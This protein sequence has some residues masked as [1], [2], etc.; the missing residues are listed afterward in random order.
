MA[1]KTNED[2]CTRIE[3]K[4]QATCKSCRSCRQK[5]VKCNGAKPVCQ[6]CEQSAIDCIYPRDFRKDTRPSKDRLQSL[7]STLSR[8]LDHMKASGID[9]PRELDL[10]DS[11]SMEDSAPDQ[12]EVSQLPTP[13]FSSGS[14]AEAVTLGARHVD[15]T[16]TASLRGNEPEPANISVGEQRDQQPGEAFDFTFQVQGQ[17]SDPPVQY[18]DRCQANDMSTIPEGSGTDTAALSHC[19][20]RVAGVFHELGC[21]SSVHGLAGV[22]NPNLRALHKKNISNL[23]WKGETALTESKA[24]LISNAVLQKQRETRLF[25]QPHDRMD[26]DGCPPDLAKHLLELHF[27]RRHHVYVL[28]YRPAFM[29]SLANGG[30]PWANKLLLNAIYYSSAMY[31]E[32]PMMSGT[33]DDGT[34]MADRFYTRFKTLLA[35]EFDSAS[36]STAAALLLVSGTLISQGKPSPGWSLSG[37]AYR[38]I[39]D[40]GCHMTLGSDYQDAQTT[41]QLLRFDLE[42]E[43][44]KRLYWGAFVADASQALYLG[45]PCMFACVEARVPLQFLDTFEELELWEPLGTVQQHYDLQP[46]Y[47]ISTFV[48]MVR[49]LRISTRI[50]ELYGIQTIKLNTD[51]LLEKWRSIDWKLE[52]WRSSLP[53]HLRLDP[54]SPSAPPPHQIVLQ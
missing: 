53:T 9:V 1:R 35:A 13:S 6:Q 28:T 10:A 49:L 38:M 23:R 32:W 30:G 24:R 19:E 4:G 26:L 21:V 12:P 17:A 14:P 29:D 11:E 36:T 46:A 22:M 43:L 8:M 2:R 37:M 44:R 52:D 47:A 40:L 34:T 54:D 25:R 48:S 5:K 31:S 20:A 33:M 42:Q 3:R 45:R 51:T 50:T 7:E 18:T 16:P 15:P 39:M 27:N 41:G